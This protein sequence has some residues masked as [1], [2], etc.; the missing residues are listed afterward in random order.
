MEGSPAYDSMG[1]NHIM[2][3]TLEEKE[4][5]R[6][7]DQALAPLSRVVEAEISRQKWRGDMANDAYKYF[8]SINKDKVNL[9]EVGQPLPVVEKDIAWKLGGW[10][11]STAQQRRN[12]GADGGSAVT[13]IRLVVKNSTAGEKS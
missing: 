10:V 8:K 7:E 9:T 1:L 6:V 4:A 2:K 11:A 12:Q 13:K 3:T 5:A